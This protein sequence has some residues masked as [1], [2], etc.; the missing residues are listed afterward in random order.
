MRD[1]E[2]IPIGPFREW[3]EKR[4][5]HYYRIEEEPGGDRKV[6]LHVQKT[7]MDL[8][9][10]TRTLQHYRY[11]KTEIPRARVEECLFRAGGQFW[12]VYRKEDFPELYE[13]EELKP[14][15]FMFPPETLLRARQLHEL[16]MSIPE[17]AHEL[18]PGSGYAT[19]ASLA[20]SFRRAFRFQGWPLR[21]APEARH[22]YLGGDCSAWVGERPCRN[23]PIR[24]EHWCPVHSSE[25]NTAEGSRRGW[26]TQKQQGLD[27][28]PLAAWI[29]RRRA[30]LGVGDV[31]LAERLGVPSSYTLWRLR[32]AQGSCG[33]AKWVRR[34]TVERLL[35]ADGTTALAD[36]YPE[37]A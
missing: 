28:G 11:S 9:V 16:G 2:L 14:S 15:G 26:E 35:E 7:A 29:E 23:P 3:I 36:L 4:V 21:S 12:E 31:V 13:E 32:R 8:G 24:G 30:E 6:S 10:S 1:W 27:P 18:Y 25:V 19:E 5:A 33:A 20:Q 37:A 34:E 22:F 17:I